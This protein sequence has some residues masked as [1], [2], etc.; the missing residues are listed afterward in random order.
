MHCDFTIG[1]TAI[2]ASDGCDASSKFE[3]LRLVLSLATEAEADKA[4]AALSEG[5]KV[6][7]PLAKTFWSPKYGM[8]TDKLGLGC[9]VMVP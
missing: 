2:L 3:G 5:G 9:R 1:E 7:M 8:S 4:F 6:D